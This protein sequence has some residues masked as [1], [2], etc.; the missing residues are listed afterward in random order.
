MAGA[1]TGM[2]MGNIHLPQF[3]GKNYDYWSITMKALFSSQDLWEIVED[4]F[5]EPADENELDEEL[6]KSNKKRIQEPST[7][8]IK[9]C[10]RVC[11]LG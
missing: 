9:Q 8:C 6:L 1:S 5:Y 4:G 2:G 7:F 10:M 3:N 11:F